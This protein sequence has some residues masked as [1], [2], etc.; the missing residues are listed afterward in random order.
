MAI[1]SIQHKRTEVYGKKPAADDISEGELA[2]NLADGKIFSK[3]SDGDVVEMA[4]P[5][6]GDVGAVEGA[7]INI[8]PPHTGTGYEED[9]IITLPAGL[10]WDM[11]DRIEVYP[12]SVA[13]ATSNIYG[14]VIVS[15]EV[16]QANS[17][18]WVAT[19]FMS[20]SVYVEITATSLTTA[21]INNVGNGRVRAIKGYIKAA[22]VS[23]DPSGKQVLFSGSVNTGTINLGANYNSFDLLLIH[24]GNTA[25]VSKLGES[26]LLDTSGIVSGVNYEIAHEA[27]VKDFRG[28]FNGST[29]T[30][31]D[32]Y[33]GSAYIKRIVGINTHY[34]KDVTVNESDGLIKLISSFNTTGTWTVTG[35]VPNKPM[36]VVTAGTGSG[37]MSSLV[38]PT[39]GTVMW[40]GS[41]WYALGLRSDEPGNNTPT[42]TFIPTTTSVTFSVNRK[43]SSVTLQA[44]Q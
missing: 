1:S 14:A 28:I 19:G 18:T 12:C 43:D 32:N 10:T 4:T 26:I 31:K 36:Y 11:F 30:I 3:N 2:L 44:W 6:G 13:R 40:G 25:D 27:G 37:D 22:S 23:T 16:L 15:K 38:R 20:T 29:F 5:S 34:H 9:T 39:A 21:E 42:L 7:V 17:T 24:L 35:V 8:L 41:R 33:G